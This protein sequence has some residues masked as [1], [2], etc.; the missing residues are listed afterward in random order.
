M[1]YHRTTDIPDNDKTKCYSNV[2]LPNGSN[3]DYKNKVFNKAVDEVT[4]R[5]KDFLNSIDNGDL[6]AAFRNG[7]RP[8]NIDKGTISDRSPNFALWNGETE[9]PFICNGDPPHTS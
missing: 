1:A 8:W 6:Y 2:L 5:L 3:G 7:L 9:F 4:K